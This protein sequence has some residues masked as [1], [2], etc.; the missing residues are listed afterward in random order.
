[1]LLVSCFRGN[2]RS[3]YTRHC[4]FMLFLFMFAQHHNAP[5]GYWDIGKVAPKQSC[6]NSIITG[7]WNTL[8]WEERH[9]GN[10]HGVTINKGKECKESTWNLV[11]ILDIRA[12]PFT[13]KLHNLQTNIWTSQIMC[14]A[15]H[16]NVFVCWEGEILCVAFMQPN[17]MSGWRVVIFRHL[18][19]L[20][21]TVY[22][23]EMLHQSSR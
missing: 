17:L 3:A 2:R 6:Q 8:R 14:R 12:H 16:A 5:V 13:L 22:T 7:W 18:A 1:M 10:I 19:Q 11:S 20:A 4:F 15:S 21:A 23:T 9:N